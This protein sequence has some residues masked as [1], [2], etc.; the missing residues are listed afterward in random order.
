M[1]TRFYGGRI[2]KI[3]D[4]T[5][6]TNEEVWV[7]DGRISYVG[8]PK[9]TDI[10][11]DREINLK[12]NLLMPGFKNAHTHSPM[13][14]LRSFADDL[15]LLD[16]LN[17]QILPMEAKLK[18]GDIY[19]LSKLAILEYLS[20][21]ITSNFDMY[22]HPDENVS[23]SID[24]GFRTVI[25]G[26]VNNFCS[27]PDQMR[28][29]YERFNSVNKLISFQLGFHAEY[30]CSTDLLKEI[31]KVAH[32]YKAP[33]YTH[34]SES[35]MEVL[36]CVERHGTTPT[37]FLDSLGMFQYGGGGFHCV[38][39]SDE[40]INIFA[41]RNLWAISN[42]GSNVKLAS[43]IAPLSKMQNAGIRLALGTD[44]PA[45]NNCL[46]MFRE[47]FLATGLQ[48]LACSNAAEMDAEDVLK[49]ATLGGA[50]AMGLLG[51]DIIAEGKNADLIVINMHRPN[52]QP[53][54]NI[55]KNLVYSGS[56][57]NIYLTM[58]DGKI[59]YENGEFFIGE[60][61][62]SIYKKANEII[63]SIR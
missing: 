24:S 36:E 6:I 19:I 47:M 61:A 40:D 20:S 63:N 23:A 4:K 56:K 12:G 1:N 55:V 57:E 13:T 59:L 35:Q 58:V 18:P 9:A 31:A 42:P 34:N 41:K 16:W 49:M 29:D 11:W 15:P 46:D 26:A 44:G 21:G 14:F 43:G 51:S 25:C 8:Q 32:D 5:E 52:M 53:E 48:K 62:E 28:I 30:T 37:V 45:S 10:L 33:V 54:N 22:F 3:S 38:H 27:S 7:Q 60:T 17:H 50:R 2:L 39:M